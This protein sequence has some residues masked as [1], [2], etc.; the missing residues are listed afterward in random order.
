[1]NYRLNISKSLYSYGI[2]KDPLLENK[3]LRFLVCKP[4]QLYPDPKCN[5]KFGWYNYSKK[6]NN[7]NK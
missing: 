7:K 1:M 2:S 6:L 5:N 4:F 3:P